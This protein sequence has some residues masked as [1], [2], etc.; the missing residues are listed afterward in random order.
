MTAHRRRTAVAER[1]GPVKI[2]IAYNVTVGDVMTPAPVAIGPDASL[3]DALVLMRANDVTG[4][5]VVGAGG[6]LVGVV[7]QKDLARAVAVPVDLPQIKGLLDVL[8]VGVRGQPL[9]L[10]A[11]LRTALESTKVE[12]AMSSPPFSV[13]ADAPLELAMRVMSE[14]AISRLPV[15]EGTRLVGIVTPTDLIGGVLRGPVARRPSP[16]R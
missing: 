13:R 8:M 9:A 1:P 4:V 3:L 12:D 16:P 7:S 5:P 10:L 14:R 11:K 6:E 15:I 2:P